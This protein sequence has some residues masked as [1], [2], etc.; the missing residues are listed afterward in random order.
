MNVYSLFLSLIVLIIFIIRIKG[1]Y[2]RGFVK[3]LSACISIIIAVVVGRVLMES[4]DAL[5]A[6]RIS[7]AI[8]RLLTLGVVFGLYKLLRLV[9]SAAKIF[10]KL[11]IIKWLD[12]LLGI[13]VGAV[14][15]YFIVRFI[16]IIIKEWVT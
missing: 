15:A 8:Y 3:E 7:L 13:F 2:K 16:I 9:I 1:G 4:Y 6:H 10:S 12:K 11:P 5:A 14:E